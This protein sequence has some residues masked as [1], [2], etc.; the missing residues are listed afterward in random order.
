MT[1]NNILNFNYKE[2]EINHVV[3]KKRNEQQLQIN[4]L[5]STIMYK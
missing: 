3:I 1:N 2:M 5:K 4:N